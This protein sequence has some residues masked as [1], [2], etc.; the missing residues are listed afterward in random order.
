[1]NR[2][3]SIDGVLHAPEDAKV[4]VYDRGF[5]YGDSVF[6]TIRTYAGKCFALAE[7]MARLERSA[8]LVAIPMPIS[9]DALAAEILAAV[10]AS[11]SP[12]GPGDP[13]PADPASPVERSVR[14]MLSRGMG[15]LGLDPS[16]AVAP[17]RVILV[18]P[19]QTPASALYRDGVAVISVRT[20]RA[21]D[22]AHGAKVGNYLAS[23]LA[24]RAARAAG[25]HEALVLDA[26]GR[27]IEGTT[28]NVFLVQGG[29][30]VTP[31]EEA[32]ILAGITRAH[33]FDV[34]RSQ[35]IPVRLASF[36]PEELASADEAFLSSTIREVLSIVRIDGRAIGAGVPG[37]VTR[38]LHVAFRQ[39]VG[40]GAEPMPWDI[41]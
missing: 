39:H 21:A 11:Q 30:L 16:A 12:G 6:E 40:L 23:L 8:A 32:G 38:A 31:P 17:L 15:P 9:A 4:S 18:E 22:A 2:L 36:T 13:S 3:V 34:A 28:S 25:A 37:R 1:M 5:L 20:E 27:I 41:A 33:L 35:G 24:L 7:H 14:I 10:S 29:A 19:L 26:H